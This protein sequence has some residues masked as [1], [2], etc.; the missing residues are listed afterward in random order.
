MNRILLINPNSSASC[1]AGM[2]EAVAPLARLP[3]LPRIETVALAEGPPAI[4][5]WRDWYGVA[6]PMCRL[7]AREEAEAYI[8]GCVSDPGLEAVRTVTARPVLGLFRCAI[9]AA[10][11]RAERFGVIGFTHRSLP[12]QRRALQA[13]GAEGR[14]AGW[15]P[16]DLPMETLTD[17]EAPRARLAAAAR[18][19]AE[20]G[21]EVIIL[22][23]AG[24]AGH[25]AYVAEVSGLPVIEPSQAAAAQALAAV[26]GERAL[27]P[28][29]MA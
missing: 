9:A 24:M 25:A 28:A 1:T 26:I 22:G 29:V 5:S 3:G 8:I 12:R 21:A 15:I 27:S 23:C 11:A 19:L 2:A 20:Q 7:V 6:E 10:Q 16:L 17:P 13:M 18:G 4:M 14:M